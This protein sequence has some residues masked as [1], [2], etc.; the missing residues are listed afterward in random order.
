MQWIRPSGT[1][2]K[3]VI[4]LVFVLSVAALVWISPLSSA[5]EK[6]LSVYAPQAIYSLQVTDHANT[7][8]AGVYEFLEPLGK[9]QL[10]VDSSGYRIRMR[11][12]EGVF[13]EGASKIR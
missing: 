4:T 13:T 5:E 7:E 12:V 6:K 3:R 2:F 8:Y 9:V 11:D 1:V 10:K